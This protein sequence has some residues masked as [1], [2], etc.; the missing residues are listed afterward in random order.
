MLVTEYWTEDI[1]RVLRDREVRPVPP[2]EIL[3]DTLEDMEILP[4]DFALSLEVPLAKLESILEDREPITVDLALRIG[5]VLG[6][7]PEFWLNLQRKV[8]IWD[9]VYEHLN[10]YRRLKPLQRAHSAA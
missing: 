1:E 3:G 9:A 8:D 7:D 10:E 6:N 4:G 2:G 5:R